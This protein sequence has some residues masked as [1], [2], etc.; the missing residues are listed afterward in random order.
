[1]GTAKMI[2][3][4][5]ARGAFPGPNRTEPPLLP[6]PSPRRGSA[7]APAAL[8]ARITP[9]EE[10]LASL[11]RE[12]AELHQGL[13]AAAQLQRKLCAPRQL[14]RGQFEIASEIFPVRYFS[15][16]FYDVL[17]LG[18]AL[19]LAV[20]DIAGKGLAAGLWFTHLVGLLRVHARS[21]SN[22]AESMAAVNDALIQVHTEPPTASLFFARLD[23]R[24]GELVYCNAGHPPA[25]VLK[26]DGTVEPLEQG[27]PL[28]GAVPR[29]RFA[30]GRAV[31][32][33]GDTLIAYSDGIVE[34]RNL[35][36]D[37]FGPER[38]LATARRAAQAPASTMLFSL[39][40]AAQDFSGSR[41]REDD[42]ALMVVRRLGE[43]AA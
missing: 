4:G 41:P 9:A 36:D 28:L 33:P 31:L 17:D 43:P 11:Q 23:W 2:T 34:C 40:G 29:A 22:P 12:Q 30:V 25:L 35:R 6:G 38:L 14:R 27:G 18:R 21:T 19:G 7:K 32:E 5:K 24:R 3:A 39:L 13:F 26:S 8:A 15:G 16:D 1:M 20:G 42:F 10:Q 37:E